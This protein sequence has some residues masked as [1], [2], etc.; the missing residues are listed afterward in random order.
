[1]QP[2]RR[3]DAQRNRERI[4]AAATAV[5]ASRPNASLNEVAQAAG[6]TRVTVHRHF[7]ARDDLVRAVLLGALDAVSAAL[8]AA[9]LDQGAVDAALDRAV[10]AVL[11]VAAESAILVNGPSTDLA[12][13]H[14]TAR[15]DEAMA[16]VRALAQRGQQAG[17]TAAQLPAWWLADLVFTVALAAIL[18]VEDGTASFDEARSLAHA[19]LRQV[20]RP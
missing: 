13:Q 15:F 4:V 19:T 10:D 20:A 2:P 12:E 6:T 17:E 11:A 18:R 7:P 16:P 8:V 1:M 3:A 14:L 9:Q 5:F